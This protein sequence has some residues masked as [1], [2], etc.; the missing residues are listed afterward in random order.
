MVCF[1][2][3][4]ST[5]DSLFPSS[6]EMLSYFY[7]CINLNC[8]EFALVCSKNMLKIEISTHLPF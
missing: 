1:L 5:F 6:K 8:I 4:E 2:I 3:E 7:I